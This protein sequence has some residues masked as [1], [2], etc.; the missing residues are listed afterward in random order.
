MHPLHHFTL[1][2]NNFTRQG[3]S[4]ATQRFNIV[5]FA[6][7]TFFCTY[8][9]IKSFAAVWLPNVPTPY[10]HMV[11]ASI[12]E[13]VFNNCKLETIVLRLRAHGNERFRAFS[14]VFSCK[15]GCKY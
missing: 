2:P 10:V 8:E 12:G 6:A 14:F 7:A 9:I 1:M 15:D 13:L 4:A 11:A 5:I 3:K